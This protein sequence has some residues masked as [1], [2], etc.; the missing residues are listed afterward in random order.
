MSRPEEAPRGGP[1]LAALSGLLLALSYPHADL[2]PLALLALVPLLLALGR[3]EGGVGAGFRLGLLCGVVFF[4]ALLYWIPVVM[5][6]Y[7]GLSWALGILAFSPL[8]LYLALYTAL[9]GS[10]VAAARRQ[11]GPMALLAAPVLWTG[12]E[13]IRGRALTG[14]PWGLLGYTQHRNLGLLQAAAV[15][16]IYA[17]SFLVMACN[18]GVALLLPGGRKAPAARRAG[19]ALL[20]GVAAAQAGG[21][22]ALP[23]RPADGSAGAVPVAAIQGNVPQ[24]VKWT[25]GSGPRI[26][27]DL[28]RLTRQAAAAGARLV[29]WPESASPYAFNRPRPAATPGEGPAIEPDAAYTGA[30]TGLARGLGIAIIAGSVDYRVEGDGL[31]AYNSAFA[32]APDGTLGPSYDKVHLVPFGEYV[33][34]RGLLF[35]VDRLVRGAISDF[36][37]GTRL[38]PLPTPLGPAAT[39]ICYEAILPEVVRAI[40]RRGAVVLVNLTNDGWYGKSAAPSQHLAMAVAR[41]VENRRFMVRAANTGNSAVIDPYGRVLARTRLEEQA[42]L[43]AAV[44]PRRD[45]TFYARHGDWLA[46]CCAILTALHAALRATFA[47]RGDPAAAQGPC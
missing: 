26:V 38:D 4:A 7:G 6:T 24:G 25:P 10:L 31:V 13:L 18:A 11:V 30:V 41:A 14:F 42:V 9:F 23:R 36:A 32:V 34:L 44:A 45:A 46:W 27:T 17:V 19:A 20:L 21:V 15:G 47:R 37:P 35:F 8:V 29:V 22:L 33:P 2:G 43:I 12:L 3:G 40:A 39:F 28:V 16:G 5:V 1:W